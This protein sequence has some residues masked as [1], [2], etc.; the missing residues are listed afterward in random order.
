MDDVIGGEYVFVI[1][2]VE[3]ENIVIIFII[4][5]VRLEFVVVYVCLYYL[6]FC[7]LVFLMRMDCI[8][9]F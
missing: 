5:M 2:D 7:K 6:L 8:V 1:D 3:G 9:V 4:D